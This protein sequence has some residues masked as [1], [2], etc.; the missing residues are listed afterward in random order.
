MNER[1]V[2]TRWWITKNIAS[3]QNAWRNA[4]EGVNPLV[5]YMQTPCRSFANDKTYG[6]G[7]T[8][9]FDAAR[10]LLVARQ[11]VD[12]RRSCAKYYHVL[13]TL[14]ANCP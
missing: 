2:S 10:R 8:P 11:R 7:L 5:D 4:C 12:T 6:S 9:V 1:R 14:D 13:R 3:H